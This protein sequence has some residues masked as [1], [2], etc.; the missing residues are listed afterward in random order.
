M[1]WHG[2]HLESTH[3]QW[4]AT[5]DVEIMR[6]SKADTKEAIAPVGSVIPGAIMS[7]IVSKGEGRSLPMVAA[8]SKGVLQ[9]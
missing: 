4:H 9:I 3:P 5:L 2:T 7:C 8:C 6:N 1:A